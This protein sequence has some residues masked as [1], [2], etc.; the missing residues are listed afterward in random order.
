[1]QK[2]E[3]LYID[4]FMNEVKELNGKPMNRGKDSLPAFMNEL[5]EQG[6]ELI[7][8]INLHSD[9]VTKVL[10]RLVFKHQKD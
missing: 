3:Y 10:W 4:A 6:W 9:S 5:G 7:S 1:M 2:W 8:T